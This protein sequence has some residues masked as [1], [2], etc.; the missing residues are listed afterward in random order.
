MHVPSSVTALHLK[1]QLSLHT[2]RYKPSG[3]LPGLDANY[4]L[5]FFSLIFRFSSQGQHIYKVIYIF[6]KLRFLWENRCSINFQPAAISYVLKADCLSCALP[7]FVV[8]VV[9][10]VVTPISLMSVSLRSAVGRRRPRS[11]GLFER[12]FV[13]FFTPNST[14][15]SPDFISV[16]ENLAAEDSA[17]WRQCAA[18]APQFHL[19][20]PNGPKDNAIKM[21]DSLRPKVA[22]LT[23][24]GC[25]IFLC[26]PFSVN[27]FPPCFLDGWK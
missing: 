14:G 19:L 12:F 25:P 15:Y 11:E 2:H 17:R 10:V 22:S 27:N 16:Q 13:F 5:F 21:R 8:V 9:V 24:L 26:P 6:I 23:D 3:Y 4:Y 20:L 18:L 7:L 1:L